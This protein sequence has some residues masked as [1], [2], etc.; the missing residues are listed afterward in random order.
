M[1]DF[2]EKYGDFMTPI[3]ADQDWWNQHVN[4]PVRNLINDAYANGVDLLRTPQGRSM[5]SNL[6]ASMPYGDMAKV[7]LSAENAREYQKA[8]RELEA[9]GLFNPAMAK[10]DGPDMATYAT[11]GENGQ[12]VWDKMSPTPF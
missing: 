2:R 7:R 9:K 11:V 1:K 3:L 4:N 12:G 6:I 8:R 10:Y 5:V